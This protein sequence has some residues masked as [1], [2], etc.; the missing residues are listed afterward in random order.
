MKKKLLL[1]LGLLC[2]CC[3][4]SFPANAVENSSYIRGTNVPA[5]WYN[6][7]SFSSL[8]TIKN[9]SFNTVRIVWDTTG[10]VEGLNAYLNECERLKLKPIVEL[11]DATGGTTNDSLNK[12]L[13]YWLRDDVMNVVKSHKTAWLNVANEWGPENNSLWRDSY[14]NAIQ[15]IRSKGYTN[16]IIV[17]AAGWGQDSNCITKYGKEVF[18]SDP[19]KNTIFSIHM[20]GSWNDNGKIKSF[21]E[22]CKRQGLPVIVGEFGYNS[23]NGN[24][25]LGC[26]VD[27][28]FLIK[29][30]KENKIGFLAWS[31]F[32]NDNANA[33]LDMRDSNDNYTWW[34]KYVKNNMW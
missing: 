34:G 25:N 15:K 26:K 21:F 13:N 23:D 1:S 18:N 33:W 20:Y 12:C 5:I 30:C 7:K 19:L 31:W 14:K 17:D 6:Q 29:Y 27:V 22:E 4:F 16:P 28:D 10:S 11:H 24:N 8:Q 2:C 9:E 3:C 32:G